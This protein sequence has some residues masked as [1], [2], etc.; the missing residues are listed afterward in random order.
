MSVVTDAMPTE[1]GRPRTAPSPLAGDQQWSRVGDN[2]AEGWERTMVPRFRPWAERLVDAGAPGPGERVLDAACGTGLAAR[3]AAA[4]AGHPN[5]E[6][7]DVAAGMVDVAARVSADDAAPVGWR[8][9]DAQDLP[10]PDSSFDLVLA[11]QG[12]QFF[13]DPIGALR[14]M[15]RV[16]DAGGRLALGVW[17]PFEHQHGFRRFVE[18]LERHLSPQARALRA[19]ASPWDREELRDLAIDAGFADVHV[20]ID[21]DAIRFASVEECLYAQASST[22]LGAGVAQLPPASRRTLVRNLESAL[23]DLCDDDGLVVVFESWVVTARHG[24]GKAS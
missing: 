4:R 2:M 11:N 19:V 6:G 18:A 17:R 20:G 8:R 9:A 10:Y 22:P 16:L 1:T 5:V 14:E 21:A 12:L 23:D 7:V 15:H 24:S 13:G 3:I